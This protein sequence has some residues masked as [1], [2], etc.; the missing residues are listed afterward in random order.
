M[1]LSHDEVEQFASDFSKELEQPIRT[2]LAALLHIENQ[3][4][5]PT[6]DPVR[7]MMRV[8]VR[9]LAHVTFVLEQADAFADLDHLRI[10]REPA[11]VRDVLIEVTQDVA[12]RDHRPVSVSCA[13]DLMV[14]IDL[15]WVRQILNDL[16]GAALASSSPGTQVSLVAMG[17]LDPSEVVVR[18]VT[19]IRDAHSHAVDLEPL[20]TPE[21][22]IS[23]WAL[24]VC[25]AIVVAHGGR[26]WVRTGAEDGFTFCMTL[27]VSH[28]FR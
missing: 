28:S 16:V 18:N 7:R 14:E 27:P 26:F 19:S 21:A 25:R 1:R 23:D 10:H 20:A 8:A 5:P 11:R 9:N 15:V 2:A 4:L 12:L 3:L 24:A 13:T 17:G 6:D 22:P